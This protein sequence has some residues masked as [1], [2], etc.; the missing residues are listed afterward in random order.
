MANIGIVSVSNALLARILGYKDGVIREIRS[1]DIN[2]LDRTKFIIEHPS[3]P[4]MQEGNSLMVTD[5]LHL[6]R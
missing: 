3:M 2:G 4:E 5:E 1:S 6:R